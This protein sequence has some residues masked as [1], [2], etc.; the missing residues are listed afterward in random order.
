MDPSANRKTGD[1]VSKNERILEIEKQIAATLWVQAVAQITEAI[2]LAKLLDLK[3]ET[4]GERKILTGVW[5]QTIGQTIE[6][7]AVTKEISAVDPEIIREAQK[8]I[9]AADLLQSAGAAIE[10]VGGKQVITEAPGGF[11]P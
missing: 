7:L 1:D 6:V 10:A 4:E 11:V 3:G 2:L 8:I 9:V 5:V